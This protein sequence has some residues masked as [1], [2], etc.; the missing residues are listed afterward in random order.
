MNKAA[1][2][3]KEPGTWDAVNDWLKK[4]TMTAAPDAKNRCGEATDLIF[5]RN[6][7]TLTLGL[8]H[9]GQCDPIRTGPKTL[10]ANFLEPVIMATEVLV[11]GEGPPRRLG[12]IVPQAMRILRPIS[13]GLL[14]GEEIFVTEG[15]REAL[16][17]ERRSP[18][19]SA[20]ISNAELSALPLCLP[21]L[22]IARPLRIGG[23]V[24]GLPQPR[25]LPYMAL[26]AA[27]SAVSP[28]LDTFEEA[29]FYTHPDNAEE[30]ARYLRARGFGYAPDDIRRMNAASDR[31]RAITA[32]IWIVGGIM[33]I[34]AFF[35][36]FTCVVAFMEKN[37]RPN[38]VLRAYGLT[39]GNLRRQ[40][41]WRLGAISA[42]SVA[43]LML[44]GSM[45]GA[46]FYFLFQ[47][48]GLPL[49]SVSDVLTI[50]AFAVA[51]TVFGMIVVVYLSVHLWWK[52]HA[53]IAQELG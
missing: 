52:T 29:V 12:D 30:L 5:G 7:L 21:G 33:V 40:I 8:I 9:D 2:F 32:L 22:N 26:V 42:Y 11:R 53:C 34:A 10:V 35:F 50:G 48:V 41:F 27:G 16:S 3:R 37:A 47:Y 14:T 19:S 31:F 20:S 25:G 18:T 46:L 24:R 1:P 28:Q 45:L 39:K 23:I 6:S 4:I 43:I 13:A 15:F 49:P 44:V 17:S 38:A 51:A 36:L